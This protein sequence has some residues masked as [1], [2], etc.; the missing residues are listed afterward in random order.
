MNRIDE[1]CAILPPALA[2]PLLAL[3]DRRG[4]RD[5]AHVGLKLRSTTIIGFSRL[6]LLAGLRRWRPRSYGYAVAQQEIAV[7][8]DDI[9][10]ACGRDLGLALEIAECA[11]LVKGYGETYKRGAENFE[12]I[13]TAITLPALSGAI[14]VARAIDALANARAAALAD[15]DGDRLVN[16]LVEITGDNQVSD[17]ETAELAVGR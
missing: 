4:W 17:A 8:L 7:W 6:R 15:P 12:R 1:L 13:R 5:R 9:K 11:R 14:D 2:R 3:F 10:S 16:L